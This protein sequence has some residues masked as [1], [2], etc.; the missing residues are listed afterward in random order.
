MM[1]F[2]L[3]FDA[4]PA[5]EG[6]NVNVFVLGGTIDSIESKIVPNG[7]DISLYIL[8]VL[9][10]TDIMKSIESYFEFLAILKQSLRD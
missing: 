7:T 8:N 2:M 5:S 9:K 10:K 1:T 4:P 6:L 3:S